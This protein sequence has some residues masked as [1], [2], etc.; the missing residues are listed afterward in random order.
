MF[1]LKMKLLIVIM[2]LM[3]SNETKEVLVFTY[4]S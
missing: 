1:E 4:N 3:V 2:S